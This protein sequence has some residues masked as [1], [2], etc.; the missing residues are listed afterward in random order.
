MSGIDLTAKAVAASTPTTT[1]PVARMPTVC[2][3]FPLLS[4]TGAS[5]GVCAWGRSFPAV[6]HL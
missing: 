6:D 4:A 1:I 2:M 3:V 5:G